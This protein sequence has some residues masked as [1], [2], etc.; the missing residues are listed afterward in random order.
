[1][2][3]TL[4]E[5]TA[6]LDAVTVDIR[7]QMDAESAALAKSE[8][9]QKDEGDAPSMPPDDGSESSDSAPPPAPEA[10]DAP[11]M[12]DQ[13]PENVPAASPEELQDLY[14]QLTP[15]QLDMHLQALMA[16]KASMGGDDQAPPMDDAGAPPAPPAPPAEKALEMSEGDMVKE[17][18]KMEESSSEELSKAEQNSD[19]ISALRKNVDTLTKAVKMLV[20]QPIRKAVTSVAFVPRTEETK[21]A[22]TYTDIDSKLR[23]LSK[24]PDLKKSERDAIIGFYNGHPDEAKILSLLETYK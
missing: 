15:E 20:E 11:P 22:V 3:D 5:L 9:V 6:L 17:E 1:M 18:S 13:Q 7:K 19:E 16:V 8:D 2:S 21:P 14:G 24:R 23:E 12:D 10:S 4:K